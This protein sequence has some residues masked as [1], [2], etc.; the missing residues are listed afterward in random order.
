MAR[1]KISPSCI[2]P[3]P[4]SDRR[5]WPRRR[6][7]KHLGQRRFMGDQI[8]GQQFVAGLEQARQ[9]HPQPGGQRAV[10][11]E[12]QPVQVGHGRRGRSTTARPRARG[13][14][15]CSRTKRRSI[16][17]QPVAGGR[18]SRSGTRMRLGIMLGLLRVNNRNAQ[19]KSASGGHAIIDD[20]RAGEASSLRRCPRRQIGGG[21][22][23]TLRIGAGVRPGTRWPASSGHPRCRERATCV[24]DPGHCEPPDGRRGSSSVPGCGARSRAVRG[25][26][27]DRRREGKKSFAA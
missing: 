23:L 1:R 18:R 9:R 7:G 19:A 17:D 24:H 25:S 16:Q 15:M 10:A 3:S 14:R 27:A 11:V 22:V 4:G 20:R 21:V 6:Q 12:R 8:V 2:S 5:R 13:G 26:P